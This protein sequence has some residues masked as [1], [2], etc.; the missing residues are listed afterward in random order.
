M[1]ALGDIIK[2]ND[3]DYAN[4]K[5]AGSAGYVINGVRY[6]YDPNN[7]YLTPNNSGNV[8]AL[9]WQ[10]LKVLRDNADLIPGTYY[11]I[12][13]YQC[14][15]SETNTSSAGH[16][17]DI[18]V[19]AD[20]DDKLNEEASAI[21][22]E[23]DTYFANSKLEAWKLWYCLDNDAGR[24]EWT[25]SKSITISG[26][27]YKRAT[28][29]DNS[30]TYP[31]AWTHGA[32]TICYTN[33]ESPT[34]STEAY[35]SST[36]GTALTISSVTDTEGKGV[37]YRMIDEYNNDIPYDF[38]NL[39]FTKTNIY[40]NRYTFDVNG[41]DYSL[42]IFYIKNNK[43]EPY[44]YYAIQRLNWVVAYDNISTPILHCDENYFGK[45]CYNITLRTR[46]NMSN[47]I[48]INSH[49][50][51][52]KKAAGN[53]FQSCSSIE[54]KVTSG[55]TITNCIFNNSSNIN[56]NSGTTLDSSTFNNSNKLNIDVSSTR[57]CIH[58]HDLIS[59]VTTEQITLTEDKCDIYDYGGIISYRIQNVPTP[60]YPGAQSLS[61]QTSNIP[62]TAP[63]ATDHGAYFKSPGDGILWFMVSNDGNTYRNI[64]VYQNSLGWTTFTYAHNGYGTPGGYQIA[65]AKDT[66]VGIYNP[67][68]GFATKQAWFIP[69]R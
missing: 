52:L 20:S 68:G 36:G 48:F 58:F 38:K 51:V 18:I 26:S 43:M 15:T 22:H 13:D 8:I 33:T 9:T 44:Y 41:Q 27:D 1:A 35:S 54:D 63:F 37:I 53:S 21:Q 14:T 39:L 62:G 17:F 31:F 46:G 28:C 5:A 49:D 2:I 12:T 29:H 40:S 60:Y 16:Q 64:Y 55:L 19:R 50:I 7:I 67:A 69:M 42:N 47:N 10:Q 34:T 25:Q 66:W 57:K 56:F 4:L 61:L 3:D 32:G 6:Y 23:G 65:V 24:F 11:R 45:N 30:D 59:T